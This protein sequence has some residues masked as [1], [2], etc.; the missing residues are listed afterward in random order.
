VRPYIWDVTSALGTISGAHTISFDYLDDIGRASGGYWILSSYVS[1]TLS[2]AAPLA[3]AV[4]LEVSDNPSGSGNSVTFTATVQYNGT[5]AGGATG[6]ISFKDGT[7]ILGTGLVSNSVAAVA[8]SALSPG[9]HT[10]T[11]EYGGMTN[12]YQ[13][14][15]STPLAQVVQPLPNLTWSVSSGQLTLGWPGF[16]GWILQAQ[17]NTLDVGVGANWTDLAGS[18]G[19]TTTNLPLNAAPAAFY[20]LRHP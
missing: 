11:A 9:T 20:R 7:N 4:K 16:L 13:A 3:T 1:A 8:T 14:S 10:I 19:A 5:N 2:A 17:S 6:T 18:E 15:T 12:F